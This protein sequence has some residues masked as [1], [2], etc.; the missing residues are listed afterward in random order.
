MDSAGTRFLR[1]L[2]PPNA[3]GPHALRSLM[4]GNE[5]RVDLA[6]GSQTGAAVL[7]VIS[8]GDV[9]CVI[10]ASEDI[11]RTAR[12]AGHDVQE[13]PKG[14]DALLS[15]H[16]PKILS[17][18]LLSRYTV[19]ANVHP[20][21][22]PAGRG[23]YPVF[24]AVYEGGIAGATTHL[25]TSELD[26]GPIIFREQVYYSQEMTG[27][28]VW[29]RVHDLEVLMARQF[30]DLV[31]SDSEI[32]TFCPIEEPGPIRTRDEFEAIRLGDHESLRTPEALYRLKLALTHPLYALPTWLEECSP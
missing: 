10:P 30:I 28:E 14:G 21:Y 13:R 5:R 32:V 4:T 25:M 26:L 3:L 23:M 8:P 18:E 17:G 1:T 19:A 22:I 9:N 29:R 15:V 2:T 24:W 12:S 7:K 11:A 31:L 20:G 6:I 16:W 27:G